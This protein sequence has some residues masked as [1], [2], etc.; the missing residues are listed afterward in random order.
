MIKYLLDT[1]IVSE[2]LR[3]GPNEKIMARL[4]MHQ[5]E[6]ALPAIVWHELWYGAKRLE[7]SRKRTSIEEYLEQV[8]APSVPILPYDAH[9]AAWHAAERARLARRGKVPPFVDGQIAAITAVNELTLVTLN[10]SD[11]AHFQD[12]AVEDWST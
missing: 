6:I 4:N 11:Y 5:D 12:I 2:T 9:A 3:R 1:N 7:P 8:L 10:T